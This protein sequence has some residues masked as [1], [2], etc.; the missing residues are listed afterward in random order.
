MKKL[1]KLLLMASL[2]CAAGCNTD[3]PTKDI[4][5]ILTYQ[6]RCGMSGGV[7]L[8]QTQIQF[9]N[10]YVNTDFEQFFNLPTEQQKE[11][12]FYQAKISVYNGVEGQLKPLGDVSYASDKMIALYKYAYALIPADEDLDNSYCACG[13]NVCDKGVGCALKDNTYV[14]TAVNVPDGTCDPIFVDTR[15][16]G[17][18]LSTHL[19]PIFNQVSKL[20]AMFVNATETL[21]SC[22]NDYTTKCSSDNTCICDPDCQ[23]DDNNCTKCEDCLEFYHDLF[24][25]EKCNDPNS[26]E[27]TGCKANYNDASKISDYQTQCVENECF[28]NHKETDYALVAKFLSVKELSTVLFKGT[29]K[30]DKNDTNV[31]IAKLFYA[32]ICECMNGTRGYC[33][34]SMI[35]SVEGAHSSSTPNVAS[36]F[37]QMIREIS[38]SLLMEAEKLPSKLN[39]K[40][41]TY[42]EYA[43]LEITDTA[44]LNGNEINK[45]E[46]SNEYVNIIDNFI[47]NQVIYMMSSSVDLPKLMDAPELAKIKDKVIGNETVQH[48]TLKTTDVTIQDAKVIMNTLK[49]M[50]SASYSTNSE[51]EK[52]YQAHRRF[53][54]QFVVRGMTTD[55]K[56]NL[57]SMTFVQNQRCIDNTSAIGHTV[58]TQQFCHT[59]MFNAGG[60][61]TY[62]NLIDMVLPDGFKGVDRACE[63][64]DDIIMDKSFTLNQISEKNFVPIFQYPNPNYDSTDPN[65][66]KTLPIYHLEV[67]I[68]DEASSNKA[69]IYF[70]KDKEESKSMTINGTWQSYRCP[71]SASCTVNNE[72]GICANS[73]APHLI[74]YNDENIMTTCTNGMP[75]VQETDYQQPGE[76]N[77]DNMRD[78]LPS[79]LEEDCEGDEIKCKDID[80]IGYI[81]KCA[82]GKIRYTKADSCIDTVCNEDAN[83]CKNDYTCDSSLDGDIKCY[84]GSRYNII[85]AVMTKCSLQDNGEYLYNIEMNSINSCMNKM[86][87]INRKSCM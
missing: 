81:A 25:K 78:Q 72:C 79:L 49:N 86:C 38:A 71:N 82:N 42:Q 1:T 64:A 60:S 32:S 70:T 53:F 16:F 2:I 15:Y 44:S 61:L 48:S 66:A 20:R 56:N 84:Y 69:T 76:Q 62:S 26:G 21:T 83:D 34:D 35:L 14:C 57:F 74:S 45:A 6:T 59:N 8:T 33:P 4:T 47:I 27:C 9:V 19:F 12:P 65:S 7:P 36:G 3:V 29:K 43:N 24:C 30:E 5:P 40:E 85:T 50:L 73:T 39:G 23:S 87:A 28:N 10:S 46:K 80:G 54:G 68:G 37:Y 77:P 52:I 51:N 18:L 13:T 63:L 41:M 75:D 31:K 55:D 22:V 58:G 17:Y 11:D 67:Y